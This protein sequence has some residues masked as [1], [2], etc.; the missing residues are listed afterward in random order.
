MIR[1]RPT[2]GVT[3]S[4][5]GGWRNFLAQRLAIR[6]AGGRAVRIRADRPYDLTRLDGVIVGGGD[7]ISAELYGG[8]IVPDVR[9]DPER[10]LLEQDII[11]EAL[12]RDLPVLGI[13]RG[14]QMINVVRGGSL[15][16]DVHAVYVDAPKMRTVLPRK[17]VDIR[18]GSVLATI[19]GCSPCRVNAL[20]HQSVDRLGAGLTVS[21]VD[22]A[23]I[24][25]A[26]EDRAAGFLLGVQWHPELLVFSRA[27]QRLF[28][29]LVADM[30]R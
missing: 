30:K 8:R 17:L 22:R 15:H 28:G 5:R 12:A 13:C 1:S 19:L 26:I 10:D 24:V 20:H 11:G 16:E 9:I 2:I 4:A 29:A 21:A 14:A 6:R 25:Q 18:E 27:Q 23:G 7:D 3:T